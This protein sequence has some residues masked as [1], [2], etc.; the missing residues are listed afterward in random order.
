[1]GVVIDLAAARDALADR[2]FADYVAAKNRA[3]GTLRILDMVAA[4]RAWERF[5]LLAIPDARE[6]VGLL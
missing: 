1:M 2:A 6:R 4:A 3:D 5:V